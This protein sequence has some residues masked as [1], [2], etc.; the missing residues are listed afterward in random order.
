MSRARTARWLVCASAVLVALKL[1]LAGPAGAQE[2]PALQSV[3]ITGKAVV[4]QTLTA[5]VAEDD[6]LTTQYQ[7]RR[8]PADKHACNKEHDIA[9]ATAPSYTVQSADVGY[10]LL[11]VA[12]RGNVDEKDRTSVIPPPPE[13]TAVT[14]GGTALVGR[15]LTANAVASFA[16]KLTYQWLQCAG[17][18]PACTEIG[19]ATAETYVVDSADGGRRLAVRVTATGDGEDTRRSALTDPVRQLPTV[20]DVTIQGTALV[21]GRLMAHATATGDPAPDISFR[22]LQCSPLLPAVCNPIEDATGIAYDVVPADAG[23]RLAVRARAENSA[24]ADT[25]RSAPTDVVAERPASSSSGFD[26]VGAPPTVAPTPQ[27]GILGSPVASLRY[28]RPFP[29]VRV[30]GILV[31]GGARVTLL[32]VT[33]PRGSKVD[34]RCRSAGCPLRRKSFRVGRIRALERFLPAG[35]R[36]TIRVWKPGLV[37]KHVRIVIRAGKAPARRDSCVL[38]G[39]A[40]PALCPAP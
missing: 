20:T 1:A 35:A 21:G 2:P 10:E 8:C 33:A 23:F 27:G 16:R 15:T 17:D 5:V 14:I 34:V 29:V 25:D 30:R 13:I 32:R 22:W 3:E 11:V 31:P 12:R 19:G 4:G 9:G 6:P 40:K 28:L 7:W 38:P 39:S 26:Q 37:G 24:G 18:A 36:I